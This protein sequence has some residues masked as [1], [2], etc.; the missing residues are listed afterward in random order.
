V[1][2]LAILTPICHREKTLPGGK[3]NVNTLG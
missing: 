3:T 1:G 2:C